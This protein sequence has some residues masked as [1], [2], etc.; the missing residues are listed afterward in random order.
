MSPE[1]LKCFLLTRKGGS[2][3]GKSNI[4]FY[5][6]HSTLC[7]IP[8]V[9]LKEPCNVKC[10][11]WNSPVPCT[12]TTICMY[13]MHKHGLFCLSDEVS[14]EAL[15]DCVRNSGSP[16]TQ[17]Q[18]LLVMASIAKFFPVSNLCTILHKRLLCK[19]HSGS[20]FKKGSEIFLH[21]LNLAI[22]FATFGL[23]I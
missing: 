23:A 10:S 12:C 19:L 20:Q 5:F 14:M 3:T 15:V 7:A 8:K 13:Y 6:R 18:A 16:Q 9:E 22:M 17:Q 11:S 2:K 21:Y 1:F 4:A